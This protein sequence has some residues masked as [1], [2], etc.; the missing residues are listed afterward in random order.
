MVKQTD[1]GLIG[2]AVMGK[3]LV[4]NMRDHGFSV[5][6]YNRTPEKT[7]NCLKERPNDSQLLG[8]ESLKEFVLSLKRPRKVMLMIQAG[9]PVDQM[10]Q[11]LLPLLEPGDV[12]IDGGNSY[13]KDSE[14]RYRELKQ[15]G[16][17]FFRCGDFWRGRRRT[18][19]TFYYAWRKPRSM[20]FGGSDLPG[21]R[22]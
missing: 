21:N 1:I 17:L 20:A 10:I 13:F 9:A 2:L 16:I 3:N 11:L 8:F 12:I 6:I 19:R 22:G 18:S 14:R 5:S 7:R 15:S 4:F